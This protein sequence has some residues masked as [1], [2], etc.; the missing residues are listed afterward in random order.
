MISLKWEFYFLGG[1]AIIHALYKF[2]W[3][4][5][6]VDVNEN[7]VTLTSIQSKFLINSM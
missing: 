2:Y 5:V 6:L 3:I 1:I 7:N 4:T